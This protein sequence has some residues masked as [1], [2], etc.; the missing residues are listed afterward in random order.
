MN[1]GSDIFSEVWMFVDGQWSRKPKVGDPSEEVTEK[2]LQF[3]RVTCPVCHG[4]LIDISVGPRK[5]VC[6]DCG[7]EV[8]NDNR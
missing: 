4:R 2:V 1:D 7:R 5:I 3:A 8:K 6:E